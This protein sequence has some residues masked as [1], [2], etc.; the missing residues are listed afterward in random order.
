MSKLYTT[1]AV[2]CLPA[3]GETRAQTLTCAFWLAAQIRCLCFMRMW[4]MLPGAEMQPGWLGSCIQSSEAG[5]E[6]DSLKTR[7]RSSTLWGRRGS[8]WQ[9]ALGISLLT[10]TQWIHPLLGCREESS[11]S[12]HSH[13]SPC[14]FWGAGLGASPFP[15][16]T[17]EISRH[18]VN[19][20]TSIYFPLTG[21]GNSSRW[22]W[23]DFGHDTNKVR[24]R[25]F[26][27]W[28]CVSVAGDG[29]VPCASKW[30]SHEQGLI[31]NCFTH[32]CWNYLF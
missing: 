26:Y 5:L 29:K 31:F 11:S 18:A 24:W 13:V 19:A 7:Q 10:G 14:P 8:S 12:P 23:E 16:S 28:R 4:C 30:S 6:C 25:T 9:L 27:L 20:S 17:L 1:S 22:L 21:L 2:S 15:Q 32:C 3:A